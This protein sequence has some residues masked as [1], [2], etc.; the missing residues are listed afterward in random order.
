MSGHGYY[1]GVRI[2]LNGRLPWIG[3]SNLDNTF[4]EAMVN[5]GFM[6]AIPLLLYVFSLLRRV[7]HALRYAPYR[8]TY[9]EIL[10]VFIILFARMLLGPTIQM[11]SINLLL[12]TIIG[13][14][15]QAPLHRHR[16]QPAGPATRPPRRVA[17][18]SRQ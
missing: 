14:F 9:V 18:R 3:L 17:P 7:H 16:R 12:V 5:L 10:V 15:A 8:T 11:Y 6:G 4:V 13:L 2:D 1:T